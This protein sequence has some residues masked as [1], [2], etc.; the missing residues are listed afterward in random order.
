MSRIS[1]IMI[2]APNSVGPVLMTRLIKDKELLPLCNNVI[3]PYYKKKS[4]MA[5]ALFNE[6]FA[7]LPVYLHKLEGAFFMWLWFKDM[8][9]ISEALYEKLKEEKVYIIPGHSFFIG[10]DDEWAHKHQC[11]RINYAKDEAT[12]RAGLEAI[13]RI[14]S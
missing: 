9:I 7:D 10:I 3:K 12:L 2:L 8:G 1:S 11:V 14:V 13:K 6:I 5:V 4:E